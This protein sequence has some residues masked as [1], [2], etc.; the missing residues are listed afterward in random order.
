MNKTKITIFLVS[1]LIILLVPKSIYAEYASA[2]DYMIWCE[3]D[4]TI[5]APRTP[6]TSADLVID[7]NKLDNSGNYYYWGVDIGIFRLT[8]D[9]QN[10]E[11]VKDI[12]TGE[13]LI[14]RVEADGALT[15][16]MEDL[17]CVTNYEKGIDSNGKKY[18]Y[19]IGYR[20]IYLPVGAEPNPVIEGEWQ[21]GK[22]IDDTVLAFKVKEDEPYI[23]PFTTESKIDPFIITL[24]EA[25]PQSGKMTDLITA[26]NKNLEGRNDTNRYIP[27]SE[28]AVLITIDPSQMSDPTANY[29]RFQ[30]RLDLN[31]DKNDKIKITKNIWS[32]WKNGTEVTDDKKN[33]LEAEFIV[34][35]SQRGKPFDVYYVFSFEK[36][37]PKI[38][39]NS[40]EQKKIRLEAQVTGITTDIPACSDT[41]KLF[42]DI[43]IRDALTN[44]M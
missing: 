22:Q 40:N 43:N 15:I 3:E 17:G 6:V 9:W 24:L 12:S 4:G 14:K 44:Q 38:P 23:I 26:A 19:A 27:G 28:V 33:I 30:I 5:V 35:I 7:P 31:A 1:V 41:E 39:L 16:H 42:L 37:N 2:T 8:S 11:T 20:I 13:Y 18:I 10:C 34:P 32:N 21:L 29:D 25:S 36:I